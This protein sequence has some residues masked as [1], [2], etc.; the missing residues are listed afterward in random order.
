MCAKLKD[1]E[2]YQ[3][4]IEKGRF[5]LKGRKRGFISG[6]ICWND[7]EVNFQNCVPQML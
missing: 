7:S 1:A 3:S 5:S 4:N 2:Q 6:E